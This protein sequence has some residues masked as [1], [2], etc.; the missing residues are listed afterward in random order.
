VSLPCL[1]R[2]G[3]LSTEP[4]LKPFTSRKYSNA[5]TKL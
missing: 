5:H 3:V 1:R 2:K 4:I